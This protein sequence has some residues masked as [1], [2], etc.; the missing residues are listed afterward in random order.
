MLTSPNGP[1]KFLDNRSIDVDV[2][3]A[4]IE[5]EHGNAKPAHYPAQLIILEEPNDQRQE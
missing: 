3:C 5:Y 4:V 2:Y 1:T